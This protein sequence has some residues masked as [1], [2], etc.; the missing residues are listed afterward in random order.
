MACG[1]PVA[2]YPVDGPLQVIGDS[3]AGAMR[4]DLTEAW[5]AALKVKRHEARDR[6]LQ[7]GWGRAADLFVSH[8]SVLSSPR[9][10]R[11]QVGM[12]NSS[13]QKLSHKTYPVVE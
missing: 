13:P 3:H 8:L 5:Q 12:G 1:V 10:P 4:E 7:F 9:R 2:A 6:A 11:A